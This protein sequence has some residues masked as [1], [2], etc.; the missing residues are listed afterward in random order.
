MNTINLITKR[1]KEI[2]EEYEISVRT[3]NRWFKKANLEIPNGLIDPYHLKIIYKTFGVP[4]RR[5]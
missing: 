3:L 2:S 4:K 5:K 1:R